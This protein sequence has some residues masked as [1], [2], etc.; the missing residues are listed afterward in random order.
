MS[1]GVGKSTLRKTI[2]VS[3]CAGLRVI[4]TLC[5]LCSPTP[6]ARVKDLSVRCLST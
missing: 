2:P 6:T 4:S 1:T 5:P 3:G